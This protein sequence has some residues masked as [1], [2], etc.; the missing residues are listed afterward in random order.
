MNRNTARELVINNKTRAAIISFE[1]F[2]APGKND[3]YPTMPEEG[4]EYLEQLII[5]IFQ[6]GVVLGYV[7]NFWQKVKIVSILRPGKN[8]YSNPKNFIQT[9]L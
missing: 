7:P 8:N 1:H 2:K 9:S 6:V 5:N 4:I 3:I